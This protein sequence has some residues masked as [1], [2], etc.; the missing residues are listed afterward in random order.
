MVRNARKAMRRAQT[1]IQGLV[2]MLVAGGRGMREERND[3]WQGV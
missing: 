1:T 3:V 2:Q